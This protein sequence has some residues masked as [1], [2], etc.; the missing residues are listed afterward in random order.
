MRILLVSVNRETVPAPVA[1]L[2]LSYIAGSVLRDG[3]DVELLDLCFSTDAGRDIGDALRR[4]PPDIV[5][6]SIRNVDNLTF[7]GSVS[8]LGEI[9]AAVEAL[10]KGTDAPIVAGGPGF[11]IFPE[12]LMSVLAIHYGI[13]GEGE[14]S[15]RALVDGLDRG[16][17][18]PHLPN[19]LVR[20][21]GAARPP[22]PPPAAFPEDFLPARELLDNRG[23]LELGGMGN[24][25]AKRGCPFACAYCTYPRISGPCLRL[26]PPEGVAAE[27]EILER[28]FGMDHV[29]FVDDIFNWPP[30][31]ALA[32][33]EAI[34]AKR[35]E[36][37]WS[38]FATP[39]GMTPV[40]ARAMKRA[41]CRGV[42][43]GTD[44]GA[45]DMLSSLGKPFSLED[46]R[47]ASDACREADLP[48][49]HYLIFGGPGETPETVS[50]TFATFDRIRPRAVLALPGVRVYP[51]TPLHRIA[52]GEGVVER[53]DDLLS[54]RFYV[55]PSIGA[56][57]L[58]ERVAAHAKT[59][60]NWVVPGLGI[61]S[62]PAVLSAL[63]RRGHRGPL[64]DM[65]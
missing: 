55:S 36:I 24:I 9:R 37:G 62:D 13:V 43:F 28:R 7:P 23:Y 32:V 4:F 50:E 6:I 58:L 20:G 14:E 39:L 35:L 18:A 65:L 56:E 2:G 11:S 22:S 47:K 63:R 16:N 30:A 44:A 57:T 33:C 25:Q 34:A 5:G 40:L 60:S 29:F 46:V 19:L 54:P 53:D 31:H 12:T 17:G 49:A 3:H 10:R 61:R 27:M 15:F 51:N 26:R 42:E 59:R 52:V 1:P 41:G 38:C 64:W 48:D 45:S 8:Y 21:K